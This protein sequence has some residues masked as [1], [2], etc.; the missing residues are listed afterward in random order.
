MNRDI[1]PRIK[2]LSVN[3]NLTEKERSVLENIIQK[4]YDRKR[5]AA[6]LSISIHTVKGH[7][8]SIFNKL[9]VDNVVDAVIVALR[10]GLVSLDCASANPVT[11]K[12]QLQI[13]DRLIS[14]AK[15]IASL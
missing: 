15:E 2:P 9:G 11:L 13:A 10:R 8:C 6:D 3:L 5:I 12:S 7:M 1:G 14:I 4:G